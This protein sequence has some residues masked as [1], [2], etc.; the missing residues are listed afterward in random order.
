MD[1]PL[2]PACLTAVWLPPTV[3]ERWQHQGTEA[4][5]TC[6]LPD[7]CRDLI[8]QIDAHG[9]VHWM[10]SHLPQQAY[11]VPARAG[12]DW[13]G[14]RLH[15]GVGVDADALLQWV[16]AIDLARDPAET[17]A[18]VH[19]A[20]ADFTRC[21][22]RVQEALDALAQAPTVGAAARALGVSE[23]TLERLIRTATGEPPRY[24]RALARV[25]RAAQALAGDE[26][27]PLA[28]IAADHGYADQAHFGRECRHWLG[29]T[30]SR[31]RASKDLLAS[32]QSSGYG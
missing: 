5:V 16:Q 14:F 4:G 22:A 21:D 20:L 7:G 29:Q 1:R 6:V 2:L 18:R 15:P 30:P 26:S 28:A 31:L 32:V 25:R 24:W 13:L 27:P 19:A 17:A 10:V 11:G 3:L 12:E 23:R 8:V 9:A